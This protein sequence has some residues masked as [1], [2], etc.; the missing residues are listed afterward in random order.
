LKRRGKALVQ[1]V[2]VWVMA[3]S[4]LSLAA[5]QTPASP[6]PQ[7]AA[8]VLKALD[9][10][11]EQNRELEQ[12]NQ[13]LSEQNRE[14]ME[15]IRSLRQ[16]IAA[17]GQPAP[18]PAAVP[19]TAVVPQTVAGENMPP[20]QTPVDQN[21]IASENARRTW[22]TYNGPNLGYKV[23]NTEH[24]DVN[25]SI[26][27]YLR[28]LNQRNLDP[29]YTDA[30]GNV[31]S[32]QQRQ[33]FQ[34]NK[35]QV[36]FLGWVLSEKFRYF[37]YVWTSNA[38]QGLGAQVVLAGNLNYT[39]NKYMTL[40][41]GITGLPGTR[42]VE[43]NFPFWLGVDSRHIADEFFR[44]SYTSGVWARGNLADRLS[45]QAMIGNN[46]STLG[47]SAA[48]LNNKFNTIASALVW[49]PTGD[50]FGDDYGDFEHHEK[51]S[52]RLAGHFTRSD[53]NKQS[54]PGTNDPENTQLRLSDGSV[55]FTPG[56]FGPGITITDVNYK[57][58]NVD[59]GLKY[60]GFSLDGA[61]FWRWLGHFQG[62]NTAGLKG[63]FDH[64]FEAQTS[65]M[66]MPKTLQLYGGASRIFGQYGDPWDFRS[67]LNFFPWK[68]KVVRWNNEVLYLYRSPVGYTAV[69]FAVGGKGFVYHSTLE[70]AF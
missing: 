24:G 56:L 67:G 30:F 62:A 57:M 34:I 28:Y 14:L 4:F 19:Q 64:G 7:N 41:G 69:P 50:P 68:N 48:Q 39:F 36:K 38:S 42:S 40:Y 49:N 66:L 44:P 55:V 10:V 12:Q 58:T 16:S 63:L 32:L 35:L 5:A 20:A 21:A 18:A 2:M 11:I 43:G 37:L 15:Q 47:V 29:T 60:R 54:Q 61:Y 1:P 59:G 9:R 31:K 65:M 26:Y 8:D 13:K 6:G 33:D 23:A 70:L 45:Y 52:T 53:E 22:G 17:Q 46:L 25:I 51:L 27:T 3:A